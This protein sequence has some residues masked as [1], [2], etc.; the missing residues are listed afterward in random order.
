MNAPL[1][2]GQTECKNLLQKPLAARHMN[3]K[4]TLAN[5]LELGFVCRD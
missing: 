5:R 3:L 4:V 1:L 2:T